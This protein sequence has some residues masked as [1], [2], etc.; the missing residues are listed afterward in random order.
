MPLLFI[1]SCLLLIVP[2]AAQTA[3]GGPKAAALIAGQVSEKPIPVGGRLVSEIHAGDLRIV[4]EHTKLGEILARF[5]GDLRRSGEAGSAAD[6][7][8]YR[9]GATRSGPPMLVWFVSDSEMSD[10]H[11]ITAVALEVAQ[12]AKPDACAELHG[13]TGVDI[14][15][16]TL[17]VDRGTLAELFGSA[18][19]D[20]SGLVTYRYDV[21]IPPTSDMS[22]GLT[23]KFEGGNAVAV[24]V[25]Q[26]TSE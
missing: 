26:E 9:T 22:Q 7:I 16:P 2:A 17:G 19:A 23:Y 3:P 15:L 10:D 18:T 8:C 13:D 5:G 4:L 25:D 24:E 12:G 6:W 21:H 14:G 20:D 1:L 11:E